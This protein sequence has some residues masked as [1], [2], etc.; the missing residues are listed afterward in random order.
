M[1]CLSSL[2][3]EEDLDGKGET[4]FGDIVEKASI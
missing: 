3:R 2:V 1:F 4:Q